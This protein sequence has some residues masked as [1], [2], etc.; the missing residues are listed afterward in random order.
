MFKGFAFSACITMAA[1]ASG[2]NAA[3]VLRAGAHAV[4][5]TPQNMPI[6][7]SGN[8]LATTAQRIASRLHVRAIAFDD[9]KTRAVVA[10][11]DSLMLSREL[12]DRIKED[13]SR[14]T[15]V[16]VAR[17]LISANHTHTAPPAMG[18]LGTDA[19]PAYA[20]FVQGR[21][22]EAVEGAVRNLAPARVGWAVVDAPEHTNCRRWIL[23]P[24]K[25]RKDPFGGMTVRAQ[26]HPG[27][28]NPDFI[29]PA[30]PVDPAL[31]LLSVQSPEGR[32][33][34]LLANYSMHYVGS[35]GTVVSAD[36]FGPF[37]EQME[38]LVGARDSGPP[39]VAIM[40]QGT[41]GDLH[42]MDY[43]RPRREMNPASY[44]EAMAKIAH[45]AYRGIE[46]RG[47]ASISMAETTL[48]LTRRVPDAQRLEW[49]KQINGGIN[50]A[51]LRNQQ[52]VY[53]REQ[54][55]IAAEPER[56]LKLQALRIGDV[57][58]AAIPNEVFAITGLKIKAQSP[59]RPTFNIALANG[60][61][62]YIP[63]PEQHVLGGYTTWPAR[64][65]GLEVNAEPKI[66]ETVLAL[67]EQVAGKQRRPVQDDGGEYARIVLASKPLAYWRGGEFGGP[68]A[69]DSTRNRNRAVYEG[70]VAF[71]LE[72]PDAAGF[73]SNGIINRAPQFAGGRLRAELKNLG[74]RYSVSMWFQNGMPAE[75]RAVTG[76]LF[77]T[78]GDRL[79]IGGTE[80]ATGKLVFTSN[81]VALE[82]AASIGLRT[83]HHVMLVRDGARVWVYL[84]GRT[85]PEIAGEAPAGARFGSLFIAGEDSSSGFE[86]RI[87][88]V[89][90]YNRRLPRADAVRHY[91]AREGAYAT[92]RGTR[93]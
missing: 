79:F 30:G 35:E 18:A 93:R 20:A 25:I 70:G 77:S 3:T 10:V 42:W 1:L 7:T 92:R 57:G 40:S 45:Q 88:E 36:Y 12:L 61:E 33:I 49:A 11:V 74:T 22:V 73:S 26:M 27:Y 67:L 9:G 65:A 17:M 31:S 21:V 54:L 71:Y 59:L 87:D 28:Q 58:I 68:A 24:D 5:I 13:A 56:E 38:R 78:H 44:A 86:G 46:Y 83:W 81:G 47:R 64:T 6:I 50:G 82:G 89:A 39:F 29:G 91:L 48:R 62:G 51:R 2:A 84:D 32:P 8:F 15:G 34:A 85:A 14:K 80:R 72:G 69:L 37:A 90:V 16:P 66:T 53:A 55:L 4:D 19:N 23:R 52:E 60:A 43:S 41:S 63:P 76:T 75:A